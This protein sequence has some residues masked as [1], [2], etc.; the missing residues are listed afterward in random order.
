MKQVCSKL[1]FLLLKAVSFI[2]TTV[3][4]PP[5]Q[6]GRSQL[7]ATLQH[8]RFSSRFSS[9]CSGFAEASPRKSSMLVQQ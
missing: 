9:L 3:P 1:T 5:I 8:S 6:S 4:V 2:W 7:N